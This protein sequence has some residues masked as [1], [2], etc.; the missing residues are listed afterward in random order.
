MQSQFNQVIDYPIKCKNLF[1]NSMGTIQL[2]M[3]RHEVKLE[4][5]ARKDTLAAMF[6]YKRKQKYYH[7]TKETNNTYINP[8]ITKSP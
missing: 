1:P 7:V 4:N 3:S 6:R 8:R 5:N 2:N